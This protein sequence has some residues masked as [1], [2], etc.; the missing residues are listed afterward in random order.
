[1]GTTGTNARAHLLVLFHLKTHP[2]G[3]GIRVTT[4]HKSHP[5]EDHPASLRVSHGIQF[6]V[7]P[8]EIIVHL[9]ICGFEVINIGLVRCWSWEL[10]MSSCSKGPDTET[11]LAEDVVCFHAPILVTGAHDRHPQRRRR[12]GT[13]RQRSPRHSRSGAPTKQPA[14]ARVCW[15]FYRYC[16]EYVACFW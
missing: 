16:I 13:G 2:A 8:E 6:F 12:H 14:S 9:V 10:H 5:P 7:F 4:S 11:P 1:M 15:D 3:W